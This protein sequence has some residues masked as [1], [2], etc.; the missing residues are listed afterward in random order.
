YRASEAIRL[1]KEIKSLQAK[2]VQGDRATLS[3]IKSK[4]EQLRLMGSNDALTSTIHK[5]QKEIATKQKALDKNIKSLKGIAP[6]DPKYAKRMQQNTTL[7]NDIEGLKKAKT[8]LTKQLQTNRGNV[9]TLA[10]Q[11]DEYS[12]AQKAFANTKRG[13]S[14][15]EA[16]RTRLIQLQTEFEARAANRQMM[17][18]E[19][20]DSKVKAAK[21]DVDETIRK[22]AAKS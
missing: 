6:T 11:N 4:Q 12:K 14:E 9:K 5:R 10:T 21:T 7:V 20:V 15:F 13:T 18:A 16:A 19:A 1:Q 22:A 3:L 2:L 17:E 8:S